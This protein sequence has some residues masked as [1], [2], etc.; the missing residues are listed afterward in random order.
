MVKKFFKWK[1][2]ATGLGRVCVPAR[3]KEEAMKDKMVLIQKNKI[4]K[5][6]TGKVFYKNIEI[7]RR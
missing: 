4:F 2:C 3:T 6:N 5:N 1:V 7:K